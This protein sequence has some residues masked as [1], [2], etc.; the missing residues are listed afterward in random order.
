MQIVTDS[1]CDLHLS[2]EEAADLGITIVPLSVT[3]EGNTYTEGPAL[4]AKAF[5]AL[6]EKTRGLPTTSQPPAGTFA[7]VYSGIAR[8]DPD[9]L[10]IHISSGLSGSLNA[11]MAGAKEVPEAHISLVD[12]KTL[13]VGAG[14]QVRAAAIAARAGWPL[15]RILPLLDRIRASTETM[16]TLRDLQYLIH[17]G[18]IS[19]MKGLIA[20]VLNIKPIIG[21]EKQEG[22]Y[23]QMGQA[24][25][26]AG[27][28]Q[29]LAD[30]MDS[31][32]SA[33]SGPFRA[34]IVQADNPDGAQQLQEAIAGRLRCSWQPTGVLSLVLGAHT[35]PTMIGA[36]L[37]PASVFE[38][39]L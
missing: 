36:V 35:G 16:F 22:R 3:L 25:S 10:S 20:S 32:F 4:N 19:H 8:R 13:S 14:W 5:Y 26:F 24:R 9:I 18:R 21:V 33:Q 23:A 2:E 29:T 37:A 7:E 15:A 39:L 30:L 1:G 31:A 27:A 28:I 6:L 11:A 38:G 12:T 17:G 34:Q